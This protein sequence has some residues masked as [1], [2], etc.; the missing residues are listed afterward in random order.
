[1]RR[2]EQNLTFFKKID[3]DYENEDFSENKR[4]LFRRL[5]QRSSTSSIEASKTRSDTSKFK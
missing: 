5:T 4:N 3:N 1:M 2:E